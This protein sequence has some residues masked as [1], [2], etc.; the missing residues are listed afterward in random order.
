MSW[1]FVK[2]DELQEKIPNRPLRGS[3]VS[4]EL[5]QGSYDTG[6]LEPLG[7]ITF[8]F[9]GG[10]A[11]FIDGFDSPAD[12]DAAGVVGE[13]PAPAR[14]GALA[15]ALVLDDRTAW[16]KYALQGRAKAKAGTSLPWVSLSAEGEVQVL[17]A[18]YHAHPL[19]RNA[20]QALLTDAT[21]LRLPVLPGALDALEV[22]EAMTFQA[23]GSLK[24]AVKLKWAD[25]LSTGLGALEE[26]A[27]AGVP[28]GIQVD[29][30]AS[31]EAR[32]EVTD[33]YVV[34][35][36][37]EE[38]R[39]RVAVKKVVSRGPGV[40]ASVGVSASLVDPEAVVKPAEAFLEGVLKMPLAR[41]E[42]LLDK[43][44]AASLEP[45]QRA[46]LQEA[47]ARLGL[48][49]E[50]S[51]PRQAWEERKQEAREA[52]ARLALQKVEAGF[53]YDYARLDTRTTLFAT[54][55]TLAQAKHLHG[56]LLFGD[57]A[58]AQ[59]YL[60]RE[61]V[62]PDSFFFEQL[63]K[64]S[65]TWGF[66]LK[67]GTWALGGPDSKSLQ[68]V[69]QRNSLAPDAP[70]RISYLGSRGYTA[71]LGTPL[72]L[73]AADLK[74]EMPEFQR[75]PSV[76]HFQYGLYLMLE[77]M[78]R[79][80]R[81][82]ELR[83]LLDDATIWGALDEADEDEAL[84][85]ILSL[86]GGSPVGTR[87]ELKLGD[88]A[89]RAVLDGAAAPNAPLLY[90]RALA[91]ALPWHP[92]KGRNSPATRE[93]VYTPIWV[94][95]LREGWNPTTAANTVMTR[96]K[97]HPQVSWTYASYEGDRG[98]GSF[99][100]VLTRNPRTQDKWLRLRMG[101]VELRNGLSQGQSPTLLPRV[102]EKLE[103]SWGQS[104]HLKAMGAFMLALL[105][106]SPEALATV[107]R[108][109]TVEL[110]DKQQQLVFGSNG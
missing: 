102:F 63:T 40:A 26:L 37:R 17:V 93:A 38:A 20:R 10:L 72:F 89:V 53:S 69:V 50:P 44:D 24:G 35:F 14:D 55:C 13:R 85:Q 56:A 9:D 80:R 29:L 19:D 95:F 86:A 92:A 103:D 47:L 83:A 32:V 28:L 42:A 61:Q 60:Q 1:K 36:S 99:A 106:R 100:E 78:P 52:L 82:D 41:F 74:A 81:D 90:A 109:L 98:P 79:R 4:V 5:A 108:S 54:S 48:E 75:Q 110:P 77:N 97:K 12:K 67:L 71:N 105:A 43:L 18:D 46:L 94:D 91:R 2:L 6:E 3:D 73:W 68:R 7:G 87:V 96:L 27:A 51:A 8:T 59:A 57:I 107:E 30:G 66:S 62:V 34:I 22:N 21:R 15:P 104:F 16:L 65:R 25:V 31:L 23:R 58:A 76:T 84:E 45:S 88:A 101:L 49:V 64:E 70:E 11:G 39:Y 33:D